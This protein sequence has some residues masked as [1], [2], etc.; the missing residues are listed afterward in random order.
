MSVKHQ[1]KQQAKHSVHPSQLDFTLRR[2]EQLLL[3]IDF[4]SLEQG[5]EERT[6]TPNELE[7]TIARARAAHH[8]RMVT[9][10]RAEE[11][12]ADI[13][14]GA[15]TMRQRCAML[16]QTIEQLEQEMAL[17][18]QKMYGTKSTC[19]IP[20]ANDPAFVQDSSPLRHSRAERNIE[21]R[22]R[23]YNMTMEKE[24]DQVIKLAEEDANMLKLMERK[25]KARQRTM[26]A[27]TLMY[28]SATAYM[29]GINLHGEH[30]REW[31]YST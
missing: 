24:L 28:L 13:V 25:M 11:Q 3:G 10:L 8:V 30:K 27:D 16:E 6:L 15:Q 12:Y 29:K 4:S 14:E 31:W 17:A 5:Q 21:W 26:L 2:V 19:S 20:R 23:T 18:K 1:Q 9:I 7:R 22:S